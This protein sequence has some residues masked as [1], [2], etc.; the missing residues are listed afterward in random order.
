MAVE[1]L[2]TVDPFS[3]VWVP[4]GRWSCCG[5]VDC[6]A[7]IRSLLA[8]KTC[9]LSTGEAGMFHAA[10]VFPETGACVRS[11]GDAHRDGVIV[12][13]APLFDT[14]ARLMSDFHVCQFSHRRSV[15][16]SF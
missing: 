14:P 2:P 13:A 16:R 12:G 8:V 11:K 1:K 9:P 4:C 6:V 5:S 3:G 10:Y 7:A 15:R